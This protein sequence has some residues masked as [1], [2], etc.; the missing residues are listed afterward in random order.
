MT[1]LATVDNPG[2]L[3]IGAFL[4][5]LGTAATL[6]LKLNAAKKEV[7]SGIVAQVRMELSAQQHP[8]EQYVGPQPFMVKEATEPVPRA[9][10]NTHAEINRNEHARIEREYKD[11]VLRVEQSTDAAIQ[12]IATDLHTMQREVTQVATLRSENGHRLERMEEGLAGVTATV[13][14]IAGALNVQEDES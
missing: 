1:F 5:M 2:A 6:F 11:A 3:E 8:P 13:N 7:I 14:R 4:V 9:N 12:R 10:F